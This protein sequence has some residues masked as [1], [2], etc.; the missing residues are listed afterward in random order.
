MWYISCDNMTLWL[1]IFLDANYDDYQRSP[2]REK[3]SQMY[4]DNLPLGTRAVDVRDLIQ[5]HA[6]VSV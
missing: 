1:Y 5:P 6:D 4:V 3:R 2:L